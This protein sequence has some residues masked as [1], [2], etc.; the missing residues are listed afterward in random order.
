[1]A[2]IEITRRHS[3]GKDDALAKL[4]A[5]M[6]A[7]QSRSP[8]LVKTLDWKGDVAA[9]AGKYFAG[10]FTANESDVSVQL[11]LKGFAA[12]MAKS[13]V[14]TQIEKALDTEFPA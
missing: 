5:L 1:M 8:D 14:K 6:T 9:A 10:T 2:D 7:F 4:Q 13:M 12:K 11:D 3:Y